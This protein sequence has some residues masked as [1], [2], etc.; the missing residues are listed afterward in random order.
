MNVVK[1]FKCPNS[2]GV[3]EVIDDDSVNADIGSARIAMFVLQ[4]LECA[5][6]DQCK[7][8]VLMEREIKPSLIAQ[9][10]ALNPSGFGERA[11]AQPYESCR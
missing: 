9:L 3:A 2:L 10:S 6:S 4:C 11:A 1:S 5:M 7:G 8:P